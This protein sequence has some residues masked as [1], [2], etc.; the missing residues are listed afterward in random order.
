M[1]YDQI[2]S[3]H[4]TDCNKNPVIV[5]EEKKC[6]Y[7]MKNPS[8]KLVCKTR[9]D[10]CYIKNQRCC[11]Y[12]I[13]NCNDK[14][15]Y[16]I[17]LKGSDVLYAVSQIEK[18]LDYVKDNLYG[19]NCYA[20]IIVSKVPVPNIQNTP[21]ILSIRKKFKKL[22]GDVKVKTIVF[23]ESACIRVNQRP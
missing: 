23:L 13:V 12:L 20:R 19:F 7:R 8:E 6:E 11:D 1:S 4:C 3:H 5:V 2:K 16:F 18:A 14:D 21:K 22:G 17:E 15:A 9:M 10:G